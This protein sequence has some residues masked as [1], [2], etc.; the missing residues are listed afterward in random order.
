LID[1]LLAPEI[2][3]TAVLINPP[4][5]RSIGRGIDSVAGLR[6]LR[7]ALSRVSPGGR[8][9]VILPDRV[10]TD[11]DAWRIATAGCGLTLHLLLPANA[12]ARHRTHQPVKLLV[13]H[14]GRPAPAPWPPA[15]P[16]MRP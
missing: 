6:H 4:F 9:A 15:R 13:L 3:P 11:S 8:C 5:S 1:D 12:F 7:A 14:K 2:R 16:S 10:Q